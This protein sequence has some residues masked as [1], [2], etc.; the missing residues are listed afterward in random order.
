[1]NVLFCFVTVTSMHMSA[2]VREKEKPVGSRVVSFKSND[3]LLA[4]DQR[5]YQMIRI[6]CDT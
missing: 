6:L 4:V 1:M 5:P 2:R 3:S